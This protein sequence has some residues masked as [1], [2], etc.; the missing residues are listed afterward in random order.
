MRV[1]STTTG[2]FTSN[3]RTE[4]SRSSCGGSFSTLVSTTTTYAGEV[5]TKTIKDVVTPKFVSRL[6]CGKFLPLNPVEI[7]TT[8]ETRV[9]GTGDRDHSPSGG[10]FR[11]RDSGPSWNVHNWLVTV[12][13]YDE[14]IL[15]QVV[16]EA[17]A[18]ARESVFDALTTLAEYRQTQ[19][20]LRNT[21]HDIAHFA[22]K[23]ARYA[24]RVKK[25][26]VEVLAAFSGKW[27]EYRYGWT[28][29]I[30]SMVDG[31]KAY[32][33]LVEEGDL[34]RGKAKVIVS[35]NASGDD[36]YPYASGELTQNDF[37]TGSRT[38][39]GC[40]YAEVLA[41]GIKKFGSDP[42]LTAWETVPF[43]FVVDWLIDVNSWLK[44]AS[45]FQGAKLLGTMA[46]VKDDYEMSQDVSIEWSG[47]AN[48]GSYSGRSTTYK[49]ERYNRFPY[50]VGLPPWNPRLNP[51][52]FIDAAALIYQQRAKIWRI[53]FN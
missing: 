26:P 35:L 22:E 16:N 4:K 45:P 9:C 44:A 46:S 21:A 52:K 28:P 11:R 2:S 38:Y 47:S 49:V 42:A 25:R 18:E 50:E 37:L 12:P 51:V 43:S 15:Q 17:A 32:H 13:A 23:A 6:K 14:D 34:I 29:L 31:L 53:L 10:C 27:L 36:V 30:S 8:T 19:R 41:S 1:R 20:M 7:V 24:R 48:V 3:A 39:R 33:D 40:A 5:K